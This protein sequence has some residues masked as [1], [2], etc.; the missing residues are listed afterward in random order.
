M[1]PVSDVTEPNGAA[2]TKNRWHQG[3]DFKPNSRFYRQPDS[4]DSVAQV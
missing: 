2:S 3:G 4:E 1:K